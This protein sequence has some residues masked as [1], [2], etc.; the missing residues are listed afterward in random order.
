MASQLKLTMQNAALS[1]RSTMLYTNNF[2][3]YLHNKGAEGTVATSD[4]GFIHFL[5]DLAVTIGEH[6]TLNNRCLL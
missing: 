1:I 5:E 3:K 4:V 2:K 6:A